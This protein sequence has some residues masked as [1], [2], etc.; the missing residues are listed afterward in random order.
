MKKIFGVSRNVFFLGLVS[1]FNDFSGEM[2]QSVMPAFL[3]S[4]LGAPAIFVGFIEGSADAIASVLKLFSGWFSDKIGKRKLP[5]V[6]GYALSV[7]TRPFLA[8][9]RGYWQVFGLRAVDRVGKGF[10]DSPRDA[11]IVE[12]SEKSELGH[13]FG[14][15]RSMDTLGATVGPL[16]AIFALPFFGGSFHKLFIL[17][18]VIGVGAIFS[19][20]FV[21][22]KKPSPDAGVRRPRL[23][24]S[25]FRKNKKFIIVVGSL[26]IFG[27]GTLPIALVLLKAKE[28]GSMIVD[29]PIMYFVY[30]F[31]FVLVAVPL[32]KLADRIGERAVIAGGFLA[33]A[34]AYFGLAHTATIAGLVVFFMVLGVYSAATDGLQRVLAAHYVEPELLATGQGFLSMA[35]GFSSLGAGLIGGWLWTDHGSASAFLYAAALSLVGLALFMIFSAKGTRRNAAQRFDLGAGARTVSQ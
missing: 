3:T 12:S 30:S 14:F 29:I 34:V 23:D 6:L 5:A 22:E 17:A 18:F 33:A 21:S 13:S 10:R 9:T 11:L 26:F 16:V 1:F 32:G 4:V 27:L 31:T 35:V 19:F 20:A 7:A 15:H 25:V 8:L 2:V 24:A 28:V